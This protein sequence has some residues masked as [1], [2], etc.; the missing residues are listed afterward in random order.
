VI[1][2]K[3]DEVK[4]IGRSLKQPREKK[5]WYIT[6]SQKIQELPILLFKIVKIF[7]A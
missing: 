2:I 7:N 3:S 5:M 6:I 4:A 1:E